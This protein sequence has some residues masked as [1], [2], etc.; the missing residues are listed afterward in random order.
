MYLS[1]PTQGAGKQLHGSYTNLVVFYGIAVPLAL[2]LG[3]RRGLGVVG[4]WA[5]MLL[6]SVLQVSTDF[7]FSDLTV[8]QAAPCALQDPVSREPRSGMGTSS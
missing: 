5:G 3:F 2:W 4:M 6:G 8:R 7:G 1:V